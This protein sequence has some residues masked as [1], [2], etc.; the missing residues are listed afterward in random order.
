MRPRTDYVL[1]DPLR[2]A[3]GTEVTD[4]AAW[5]EKRRPQ[6]LALFEN[7][8]Y[9]RIPDR[10]IATEFSLASIENHALDGRAIRKQ[11]VLSFRHGGK[12]VNLNVLMYFPAKSDRPVPAFVGLNFYGNHTIHAD[13]GITMS[14]AW[15]DSERPFDDL[16]GGKI[17]QTRGS[18]A[19]HWPVERIL[20]RGY[21]L[22]TMHYYDVD[23]DFD[24][25]FQNG[26][27]PLFYR[28]GQ[29]RPDP[30]EWGSISAWAWGL[31]RIMDYLETDADIDQTRIAVMGHSR[32][33]K[34]AL[35]AGAQDERFAI[36]ISN[37]SGCMGAALSRRRYGETIADITSMFPHWFCGSFKKYAG[38]E[39]ELAVDQHMLIALIAPRPV[40]IASADLDIW[41]DPEGEFLSAMA[42][43]GVYRLFGKDGLAA[44]K[45]PGLHTPVTSTI[46]Y[47]IR[48]GKHR[49]TPYDWDRF[50]DFADIYL[51]MK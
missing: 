46:G 16:E 10:D 42:A 25:G 3:D 20:Q 26:I 4:A 12:H 23:P 17:A 32:L 6:I 31:S 40:C 48:K 43:S 18:R 37:N 5:K 11:I 15:I 9:G 39:D 27:H 30:D 34:A 29:Q 8:V 41:A 14:N 28:Q 35:W 7:E 22:I 49:V 33:G 21:G 1:P 2:L 47:H 38:R 13:P 50:M 44:D 19:T 24:D 51:S 36:V 45:Q